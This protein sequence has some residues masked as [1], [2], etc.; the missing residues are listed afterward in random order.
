MNFI[1]ILM[2]WEYKLIYGN[3]N[4]PK[5]KSINSCLL[6]INRIPK[7][8]TTISPLAFLSNL[9]LSCCNSSLN[10]LVCIDASKIEISD[11]VFS[12]SL[13]IRNASFSKEDIRVKRERFCA[14]NSI[15]SIRVFLSLSK[16]FIFS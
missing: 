15:T 10:L 8:A 9:A 4:P 14:S 5:G 1:N 16:R 2:K 7:S 6:T 3:K 11:F 13:K 12:N